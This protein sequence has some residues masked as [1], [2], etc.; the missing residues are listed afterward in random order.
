MSN[1]VTL[2]LELE[3]VIFLYDEVLEGN[4]YMT[5]TP[6]LIRK[7]FENFTIE[8]PFPNKNQ[9][10][11]LREGHVFIACL[12]QDGL[13]LQFLLLKGVDENYFKNHKAEFMQDFYKNTLKFAFDLRKVEKLGELDAFCKKYNN[14]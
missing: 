5:S 14:N 12:Y 10:Y 2:N 13:V 6:Y 1:Q 7:N 4:I 9:R 11:S 8:N 3:Q